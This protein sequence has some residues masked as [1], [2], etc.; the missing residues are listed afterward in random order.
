DTGADEGALPAERRAGMRPAT[1]SLIG[2]LAETTWME[3]ITKGMDIERLHLMRFL[4]VADASIVC[5][6]DNHRI[7][8]R[9]K[10]L[11]LDWRGAPILQSALTDFELDPGPM[12]ALGQEQ[13]LQDVG[14]MSLYPRKQTFGTNKCRLRGQ[15]RTSES[16]PIK[17]GTTISA[18][19]HRRG[20]WRRTVLDSMRFA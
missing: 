18:S 17:D 7:C 13:T 8:E 1:P 11:Q 16:P 14:P 20:G 5:H 2:S 3:A 15:K 12:S 10:D 9:Y 6:K 4:L 19:L